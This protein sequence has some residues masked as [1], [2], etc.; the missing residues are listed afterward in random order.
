MIA[1]DSSRTGARGASQAKTRLSD[2]TRAWWLHHRASAAGSLARLCDT[3][4]QTLMSVM[5]VAIALALPATLLVALGNVQQLGE[6]WDTSPKL[7]VYLHVR[8]QPAAIERLRTA[9]EELPEVERLEYI[10]SA[11]ALSV[12]RQSSGFGEVLASLDENPLPPTMIITPSTNFAGPE[13]LAALAEQMGKES[14]V[15]EVGV[16]IEWVRRLAAA[17]ELGRKVVLALAA[18][19][20]L[21]VLLAIGNTIRLAIENRRSEIVVSKLV[22]GTD[23][24]VRRPFLYAGAW[25][26]FMGGVSACVLVML[27]LASIE[28]TVAGLAAA[29]HSDFS[30]QWLNASGVLSLLAIGTLLGLL[31]AWLAVSRHLHDIEPK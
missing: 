29:Y 1:R 26:G 10:S 22:G 4:L 7:T 24:F 18:L 9:F 17:M 13:A 16:D 12:F 27:G 14:I 28:G 20:S 23:G 19:L 15:D 3:P 8:A 11:E 2:V 30:L 5:V 6:S 21:G 25:Y 31:G